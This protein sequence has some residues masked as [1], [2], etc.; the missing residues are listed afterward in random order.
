[1]KVEKAD[2]DFISIHAPSR[3]RRADEQ[4]R[5]VDVIISIHAPSRERQNLCKIYGRTIRFQ[6]TLPR[7]S[8]SIIIRL[9]VLRSDFNPRSLAG[10]TADPE[11]PAAWLQFQSTL[12]RGSDAAPDIQYVCCYNFN[13]RSLA[14]A[15]Y[16]FNVVGAVTFISIHAPLRARHACLLLL[17]GRQ[18]NFNPR[19]LAGA[20]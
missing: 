9:A 8:D 20:T 2:V 19:S 3:E 12:P 1:M 15:T 6:S 16:G 5:F 13:P 14:G 11:N 4:G 10:A 7:G 17:F 18:P